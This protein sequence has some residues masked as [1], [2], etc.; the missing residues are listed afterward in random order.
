MGLSGHLEYH[1]HAVAL[2]LHGTTITELTTATCASTIRDTATARGV[3]NRVMFRFDV[4]DAGEPGM[5]RDSFTITV[6][7]LAYTRTG[8]TISG[9]N[10]EVHERTC[11]S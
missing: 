4:T 5:H 11:S 3:P 7:E 8:L 10:I 1:D 6:E 2:T 9:G